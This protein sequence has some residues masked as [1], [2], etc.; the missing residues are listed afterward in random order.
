M[1]LA[2]GRND[3]FLKGNEA[4]VGALSSEVESIISGT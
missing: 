1:R 4:I 2:C 3:R